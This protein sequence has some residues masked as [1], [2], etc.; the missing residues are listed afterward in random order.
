[1]LA[2][3]TAFAHGAL[4]DADVIRPPASIGMVLVGLAMLM[5][6]NL[7]MRLK[8]D[9]LELAAT[10]RHLRE[11]NERRR[12]AEE[13][14]RAR[15][16]RDETTG[17]PNR[18]YVQDRLREQAEEGPAGTHSALVIL[19][20]D[21]FKVVNDALTHEVGD[22]VLREVGARVSAAAQGTA[23]A[24]R[25]DGDAF[26]AILSVPAA[27]AEAATLA[28]E[29][30]AQ[31][32]S[33]RL[34]R[35]MELEGRSINLSASMGLVAFTA[36]GASAAE[37]LGRAEMALAHAKQRGRNNV[38]PFLA[39]FQEEAAERYRLIEGLRRAIASDELE[40]HF[41]AQVDREGIVVGAEALLRWNSQALG[42]VAPSR[43]I[44]VAE[45]TGLIHAIGEWSLRRGC[46]RLAA[47]QRERAAFGG[48]LS[49]N[50]SP[51]QLARSDFV[52]TLRVVLEETGADPSRIALEITESAVLFDL[53]E[54][55]AKLREIRSLGPRIALDDFGT[56]YSSLAL[57][58][59]LPLD[60]IKIDQA[61]VRQLAHGINPRLIR[62]IVAIG[63]EL[64]LG[65]IAEGVETDSDR[66]AL[67]ALGCTQL[68]GYF[69]GRPMPEAVFLEYVRARHGVAWKLTV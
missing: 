30:V 26:V 14:L 19:D 11:E 61:F 6:L 9:Y 23:V 32:V 50:V 37:V 16:Y 15:A 52:H 22:L 27:S 34:A 29:T 44:P 35:P 62:V 40:L 38:Q 21:H 57:I 7:M 59:D 67:V 17:M 64:G 3:L 13:S 36:G 51:W 53:H 28:I 8:E 56:G 10:A 63:D 12:V 31:G 45:E 2:L 66:D 20:L 41:Q 60:V 58:R 48:H 33:E 46:E 25:F 55:I 43:F 49:I 68:Q 54:T 4:I 42:S 24:A 1:M 65:V 39:S 47:W 5:G 69:I 18:L